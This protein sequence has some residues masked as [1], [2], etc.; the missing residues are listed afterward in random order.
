M[1]SSITPQF[2]F[3][4]TLT[5]ASVAANTVATQTV[6][7]PTGVTFPRIPS[8]T[9]AGGPVMSLTLPNLQAGLLFSNEQ[10]INA[11]GFNQF[12]VTFF[13]NTGGALTPTGTIAKLLVF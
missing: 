8:S 12:K 13:N 11:S 1:D 5:F 4:G 10:V 2:A 7:L 3:E 9:P 6:T